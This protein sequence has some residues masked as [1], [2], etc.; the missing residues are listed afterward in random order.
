[1]RIRDLGWKKFGSG[2][3]V[4]HPRSATLIVRKYYFLTNTNNLIKKIYFQTFRLQDLPI[5]VKREI[6]LLVDKGNFILIYFFS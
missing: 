5:A 1:M 4:K 6:I 3:R 2:L